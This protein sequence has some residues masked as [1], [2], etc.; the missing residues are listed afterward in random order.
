ML[1]CNEE[2]FDVLNLSVKIIVVLYNFKIKIWSKEDKLKM[3]WLLLWIINNF[4]R[5]VYVV[6][7]RGGGVF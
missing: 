7:M 1:G 3:F 4:V 5:Y 6:L 2:F